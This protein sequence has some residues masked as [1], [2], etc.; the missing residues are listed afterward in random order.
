MKVVLS[1]SC[2]NIVCKLQVGTYV[3]GWVYMYACV[4]CVQEHRKNAGKADLTV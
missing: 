2:L 4:V 3:R 1:C